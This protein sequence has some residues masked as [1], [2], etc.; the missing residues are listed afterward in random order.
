[1]LTTNRL[2][3]IC[4]AIWIVTKLVMRSLVPIEQ[5]LI[6]GVMVNILFILLVAVFAVRK[7][8]QTTSKAESTF[9]DTV[10]DVTKA[11]VKYALLATVLVGSYYYIIS[12]EEVATKKAT[13]ERNLEEVLTPE[14]FAEMQAAEPLLENQN[15]EDF[16]EQKRTNIEW[17]YSPFIQ[18]TFSL[19]AL[20]AAAIIY[21]ILITLLWRNILA[22]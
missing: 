7:K 8:F 2:I 4:G 9:V 12:P 1:M 13:A 3:W 21:S 10:K 20:I 19:I 14:S 18:I 17:I 6:I 15:Y 22:R 16:V 11:S 5:N